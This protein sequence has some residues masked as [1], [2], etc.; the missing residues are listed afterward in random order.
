M[1]VHVWMCGGAGRTT[2]TCWLSHSMAQVS[3]V[4]AG[5]SSNWILPLTQ[6]LFFFLRMFCYPCISSDLNVLPIGSDMWSPV[7]GSVCEC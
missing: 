5:V 2:R 1:F 6:N 4:P 7:G 3:Q